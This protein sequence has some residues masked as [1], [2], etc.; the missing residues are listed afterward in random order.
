MFE[1]LLTE[2]RN[3]HD[4]LP[5]QTPNRFA[6]GTGMQASYAI[7]AYPAHAYLRLGDF[8]AARTHSEAALAAHESALPGDSSPGKGAMARLNLATALVHLGAPDEAAAL[9]GQALTTTGTLNFLRPHARDLN[10]ALVSRYPTLACV[11]DFH[12]QYRQIAWRPTR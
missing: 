4:Q 1:T 12:E 11:Q 9:G 5:A 6:V 2:A 10:A 3:L 8:K 7:T